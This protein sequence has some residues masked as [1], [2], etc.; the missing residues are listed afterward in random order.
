MF[1]VFC[2]D[3]KFVGV[4]RALYRRDGDALFVLKTGES[5]WKLYTRQTGEW[6]F[7]YQSHDPKSA[8]PPDVPATR[9]E[10]MDLLTDGLKL[11]HE[12][13]PE[14]DGTTF[15]HICRSV[16]QCAEFYGCIVSPEQ[17][18]RDILSLQQ[19]SAQSSDP[20]C[21]LPRF[22]R[23]RI[24]HSSSFYNHM[25]QTAGMAVLIVD[26]SQST[27]RSN[28]AVELL[29]LT[30]IRSAEVP[31][32][33]YHDEPIIHFNNLG[34]NT[35]RAI[36]TVVDDDHWH[37]VSL[38]PMEFAN[39]KELDRT[40]EAVSDFIRIERFDAHGDIVLGEAW[41]FRFYST[42]AQAGT[43][44]TYEVLARNDASDGQWKKLSDALVKPA[45]RGLV[46]WFRVHLPNG[47]SAADATW[48]CGAVVLRV[49]RVRNPCAH[50]AAQAACGPQA[51]CVD[52]DYATGSQAWTMESHGCMC[53]A[54]FSKKTNAVGRTACLRDDLWDAANNLWFLQIEDDEAG[55]RVGDVDF[56]SGLDCASNQELSSSSYLDS[57]CSSSAFDQHPSGLAVDASTQ[58]Q[59]WGMDQGQG[60][61]ESARLTFRA[62]QGAAKFP[63][64]FRVRQSIPQ[65][66]FKFGFS[67]ANNGN[68]HL[69][70]SN[71]KTFTDPRLSD[72]KGAGDCSATRFVAPL[73]QTANSGTC[74]NLVCGHEHHIWRPS[75]ALLQTYESHDAIRPI[76]SC[77]CKAYCID[78]AD[79]DCQSWHHSYVQDSK[80]EAGGTLH[81]HYVCS[82]FTAA[83]DVRQSVHA[84]P[85]VRDAE[86][87]RSGGVG[88]V[89]VDVQPRVAT[90]TSVTLA[91]SGVGLSGT[92]QRIKLVDSGRGCHEDASDLVDGPACSA[93]YICGPPPA[94]HSDN[95]AEWD[96]RVYRRDASTAFDVCYCSAN[97]CP[98]AA[99]A[100]L[101]WPLS[102]TGLEVNDRSV[103]YL[104]WEFAADPGAPINSDSILPIKVSARGQAS[105][106]NPGRWRIKI[107]ASRVVLEEEIPEDV[108]LA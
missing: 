17:Y 74:V 102:T 108:F 16:D 68:A 57:H 69:E 44:G 104:S 70:R 106:R 39:Q 27:L 76:T 12:S 9:A 52:V 71:R 3:D 41:S 5:V 73:M 4:V 21:M 79:A 11:W 107:A 20:I 48:S 72:A 99:W 42:D 43:P 25:L 59:F 51:S 65:F 10:Q 64:S 83:F 29:P 63:K 97:P 90:T 78:A 53:N 55:F 91:V 49:F 89:I 32:D 24:F 75:D 81:P 26:F 103:S 61:P 33:S 100:K 80:S 37:S 2:S 13:C 58:S 8:D 77:E 95:H 14:P 15:R 93:G 82:L 94:V 34:S 84:K 7:H 88:S 38:T 46:P 35:K 30:F 1:F 92:H 60:D 36:M 105:T 54:G 28:K 62:T 18:N 101:P 98:P 19:F 87:H 23:N 85:E 45:A 96:L 86:M 67:A 40:H 56:F 22:K 66:D 31:P 50:S 6:I 47:V